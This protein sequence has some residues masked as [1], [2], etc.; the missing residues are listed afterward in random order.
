[1]HT[2]AGDAPFRVRWSDT[3]RVTFFYPG[4]DAEIRHLAHR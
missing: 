3:G 1:V 2:P 4:P